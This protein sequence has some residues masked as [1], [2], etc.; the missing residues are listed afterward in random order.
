MTE[1]VTVLMPVYNGERYLQQAILSILNQTFEEFELLIID[2]GSTDGSALIVESFQREDERVKLIKNE[3]NLGL[4][5]TLNKGLDLIKTKYIVRM[6]CD[7]VARPHRIQTQI[8]FME[9]HPAV[10]V[11]GSWINLQ[12][13]SEDREYLQAYPTTHDAIK[14][15][16][17]RHCAVAHPSV[18]IR[19]AFFD[20]HKLRYDEA[21]PHTED[22]ELWIRAIDHFEFANIPEVLLDYNSHEENITSIHEGQQLETA[23]LL[24]LRQ[25]SKLIT[26]SANKEKIL[27]NL[28][29]HRQADFDTAQ[30]WRQLGDLLLKLSQANRQKKLYSPKA[31]DGFLYKTWLKACR[32]GIKLAGNT[33]GPFIRAPL[34]R[35]QGLKTFLGD[36][37]LLSIRQ[38][39]LRLRS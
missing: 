1:L 17:L 37:L 34:S 33:F 38:L 24:R 13:A 31:F 29:V 3:T 25:I 10:G 5:K 19:K 30:D 21:Y 20:Q 2:D 22:Y 14:I 32:R 12:K 23:Q 18:T 39:K 15:D 9:T 27:T 7:D 8:K 6:D 26:L 16:M 28:F 4:I 11:C 35:N 36:A